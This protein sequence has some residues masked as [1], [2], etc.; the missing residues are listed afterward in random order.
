M[1]VLITRV[2]KARR[3]QT[4]SEYMATKEQVLEALKGVRDPELH[5][6]IVELGMV[7]D[8]SVEGGSVSFTFN[9][10]TPACPLRSEL[11]DSVK[12]SIK[13]LPGVTSVNVKVSAHVPAT[14]AAEQ[15][16]ILKGV[17]NIIAVA[18]GK[19]G[20]GKS[21]VAANLAIVLASSGAR[22]GLLDA[23]IYGPS[24]PI[25]MG[26][27]A[28]PIAVGKSIVPPVAHGV[29]VMSLGFYYD[30]ATPLVWRGPM[31]AGAVK[32]LLT[33]VDWGDLD[34]LIV[35]LPPGT[36]DASLTLAQTV[37]LG[38]VVVVTTPQEVSLNI[39]TKSLAMFRKLN[40]PILGIVENMSYFACPHCGE[41]T[42]VFAQGGGR[43]AATELDT[44]FLG[45]IPL[46]PLVGKQSDAGV[47][48]AAAAPD[49]PE[50]SA[51]KD[52]AFRVA[53]MVSIVAYDNSQ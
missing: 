40:V 44:Q 11:E 15:G 48:V 37:P 43:K 4:K 16:E 26:V 38:G 6:D 12:A 53:G 1:P 52:V 47:P 34:Y 13:S 18:S 36:G 51:F 30:D 28:R 27:S 42:Y 14:R 32:Q 45:E 41:R 39:A 8:L 2:I 31:V 21:T 10:T 7:E 49:S 50:S 22:V 25:M 20:V 17:K 3:G 19:G 23:D 24:V 9:L 35:D 5:K 46:Y 29:K 33:D